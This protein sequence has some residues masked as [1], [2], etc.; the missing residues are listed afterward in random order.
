MRE[1][2]N[3]GTFGGLSAG[4]DAGRP[5]ATG[6]AGGWAPKISHAA[7]APPTAA[8]GEPKAVLHTPDLTR[9]RGTLDFLPPEAAVLR[10]LEQRLQA[11]LGLHAYAP[12]ATP[13][14]ETT[15]LFL[16]KSGEE[17]TTRMYAFTQ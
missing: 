6:A 10:A 3:L 7:P 1:A 2:G 12:I 16:R 14:L 8:G 17:I 9:V 15:D 11:F 5:R 13:V 4:M